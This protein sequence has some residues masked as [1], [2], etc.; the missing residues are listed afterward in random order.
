VR[1]TLNKPGSNLA[2]NG[3]ITASFNNNPA[4][5]FN[6]VAGT[7]TTDAIDITGKQSFISCRYKAANIVWNRYGTTRKY[8]NR[9][10]T[11]NKVSPQ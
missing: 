3:G 10:F 11:A 9:P 8:V 6:D 4:F 5:T 1:A 7:A 2:C